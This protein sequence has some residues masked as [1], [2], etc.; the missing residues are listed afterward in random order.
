MDKNSTKRMHEILID[1]FVDRTSID[2]SLSR[3]FSMD[4][5]NKHMIYNDCRHLND[6]KT[7]KFV[8][9]LPKY[10]NG[11]RINDF[12]ANP[13]NNMFIPNGDANG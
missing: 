8:D 12:D 11:V 3:Y 9:G 10:S 5:I 4:A 1:F 6:E 7:I 13:Q 2:T